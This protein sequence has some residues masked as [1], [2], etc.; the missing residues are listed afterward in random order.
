MSRSVSW[1]RV[2]SDPINTRI[3]EAYEK[4][5]YIVHQTGPTG[6]VLKQEG[7]EKKFKVK[8]CKVINLTRI[9]YC[10]YFLVIHTHVLALFLEKKT[11]FAFTFYG[12]IHIQS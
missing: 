7:E 12:N 4:I 10:R 11:N 8:I 5:I 9:T 6:F 3:E 1:R 2:C